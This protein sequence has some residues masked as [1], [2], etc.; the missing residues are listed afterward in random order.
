LFEQVDTSRLF[1][2]PTLLLSY[3]SSSCIADLIGAA[4]SGLGRAAS[5]AASAPPPAFAWV[6]GFC[7]SQHA[8]AAELHAQVMSPDEY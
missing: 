4:Q 1:G 7:A 6:D 5:A 2:R 8:S 3:P